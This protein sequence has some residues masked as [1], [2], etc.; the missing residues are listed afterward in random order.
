MAHIS[1]LVLFD[2]ADGK[3]DLSLRDESAMDIASHLV[4]RR[5]HGHF[6]SSPPS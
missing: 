1:E 6:C 3:T 4:T 5:N 2:Y